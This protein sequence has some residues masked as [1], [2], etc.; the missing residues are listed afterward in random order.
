MP[1]DGLNRRDMHSSNISSNNLDLA[2]LGAHQSQPESQ[3]PTAMQT[4]H[5]VIAV[6]E[7]K[8]RVANTILI[9]ENNQAVNADLGEIDHEVEEEFKRLTQ[10]TPILK[11]VSV[12]PKDITDKHLEEA[13]AH[14]RH[15]SQ[16]FMAF[17][18][19]EDAMVLM[20]DATKDIDQSSRN[21]S[22]LPK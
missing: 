4:N 5:S 12:P 7:E 14:M 16:A 19:E 2:A 18:G 22:I 11:K 3:P 13:N 10:T 1:V 9:R 8:R 20:S 15:H 6:E 17:G 21:P